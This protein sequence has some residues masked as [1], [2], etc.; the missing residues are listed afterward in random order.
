MLER[1]TYY[2]YFPRCARFLWRARLVSNLK[3]RQ[4]T[5]DFQIKF[6]LAGLKG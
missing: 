4:F 1:E 5:E 6:A 3:R 2:F